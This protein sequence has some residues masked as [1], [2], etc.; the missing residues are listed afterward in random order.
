MVIY[1]SCNTK[2]LCMQATIQNVYL[3]KLQNKMF[4]YANCNTKCLYMQDTIQNVYIC[5]L[6]YKMFIYASCNTKCLKKM[7]VSIKRIDGENVR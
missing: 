1:A 7:R 3:R 4:M 2:N 6:Q 5:K